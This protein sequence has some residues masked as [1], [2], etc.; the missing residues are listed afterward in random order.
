[1]RSKVLS[2]LHVH[3]FIVAEYWWMKNKHHYV[4]DQVDGVLGCKLPLQFFVCVVY[5][6]NIPVTC[7]CMIF[8]NHMLVDMV[9]LYVVFIL[10]IAYK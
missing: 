10:K 9:C 1:M 3:T 5:M 7:L 2:I 4:N 8:H 6:H